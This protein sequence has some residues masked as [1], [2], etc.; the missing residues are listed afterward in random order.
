MYA[1]FLYFAFG[2]VTVIN[3]WDH[4]EDY[5]PMVKLDK[6]TLPFSN[7]RDSFRRTDAFWHV[8]RTT[9]Q[10]FESAMLFR[11]SVT[12]GRE[13]KSFRARYRPTLAPNNVTNSCVEKMCK[14][15]P[16]RK[17]ACVCLCLVSHTR[18]TTYS[19]YHSIAKRKR[20][21]REFSKFTNVSSRKLRETERYA[22]KCPFNLKMMSHSRWIAWLLS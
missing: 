14:N 9:Q 12:K 17:W 4:D 13:S 18:C 7:R 15:T 8:C 11:V 22:C 19:K 3:S 10:Q 1:I 5:K 21:K 20:E 6:I 16:Y 2:T